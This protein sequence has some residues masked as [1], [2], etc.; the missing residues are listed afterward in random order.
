[1]SIVSADVTRASI[2]LLTRAF[3][4]TPLE[5]SDHLGLN[6]DRDNATAGTHRLRERNCEESHARTRFGN[7]HSFSNIGIEDLLGVLQPP[8]QWASKKIT[9]PPRTN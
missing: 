8:T 6:I 7:G 4:C 5:D 1:M 9:Q 3:L 2:R